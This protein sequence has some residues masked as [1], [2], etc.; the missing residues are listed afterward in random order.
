MGTKKTCIIDVWYGPKYVS[1]LI[2]RGSFV[3][4]ELNENSF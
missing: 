1:G 4:I 3:V 2:S